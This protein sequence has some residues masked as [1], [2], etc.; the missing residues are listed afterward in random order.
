MSSN[1]GEEE[2][3]L[4]LEVDGVPSENFFAEAELER[5]FVRHLFVAEKMTKSFFKAPKKGSNETC[6]DEKDQK[7]PDNQKQHIS[8]KMVKMN[9]SVCL[10][11]AL[12]LRKNF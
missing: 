6:L 4:L 8:F 5:V 12:F 3:L 10:P 11:V 9:G 7:S 1:Q 2:P